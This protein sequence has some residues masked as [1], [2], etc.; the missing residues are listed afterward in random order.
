MRNVGQCAALALL[1][2]A[3]AVGNPLANGWEV[4]E[5][6]QFCYIWLGRA[7]PGGAELGLALDANDHATIIL[8]NPAWGLEADRSYRVSAGVG[9]AY[10]VRKGRGLDIGGG[11]IALSAAVD[12]PGFAG[13]FA[14]ADSLRFELPKVKTGTAAGSFALAGAREA[15]AALNQC[16]DG[17]RGA[18]KDLARYK[19]DRETNFRTDPYA[20][21]DP[22]AQPDPP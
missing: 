8:A 11:R 22:G 1:I 16:V 7:E 9:G 18:A 4:H 3:P 5:A 13:R 15:V 2:A 19:A 6:G 12:E 21:K 17:Q 10:K 14:A 20:S